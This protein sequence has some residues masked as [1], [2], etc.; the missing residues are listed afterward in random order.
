MNLIIDTFGFSITK[1]EHAEHIQKALKEGIP[2]LGIVN[3]EIYEGGTFDPFLV[4][5]YFNPV[6][7]PTFQQV[8]TIT[9]KTL[10][11]H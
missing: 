4:N 11:S 10:K 1:R 8:L 3:Y 6:D 2:S 7:L 5:F 9:E